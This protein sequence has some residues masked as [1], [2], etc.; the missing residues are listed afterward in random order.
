MT[1]RTIG[2]LMLLSFFIALYFFIA[3]FHGHLVASGIYLLTIILTLF[4]VTAIVLSSGGDLDDAKTFIK[5]IFFSE[6]KR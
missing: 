5:E 2:N 6:V 4:I 1:N 3:I